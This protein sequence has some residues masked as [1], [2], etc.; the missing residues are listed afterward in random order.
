MLFHIEEGGSFTFLGC[1]IKGN[2]FGDIKTAFG[3][4]AN[5]D[6]HPYYKVV[7]PD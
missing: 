5:L 2:T 1:I 3:W 7:C 6:G 4:W